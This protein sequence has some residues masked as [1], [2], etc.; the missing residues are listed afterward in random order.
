MGVY[1][2]RTACEAAAAAASHLADRVSFYKFARIPP[3]GPEQLNAMP[4]LSR[5]R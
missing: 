4:S 3:N 2:Q 1:G 5:I